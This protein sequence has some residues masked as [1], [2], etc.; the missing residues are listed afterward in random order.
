MIF[1][2]IIIIFNILPISKQNERLS[3]T[4]QPHHSLSNTHDIIGNGF[5]LSHFFMLYS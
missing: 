4:Y 1:V 3:L 5:E 2:R